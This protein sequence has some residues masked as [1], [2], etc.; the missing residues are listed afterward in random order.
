[1]RLSCHRDGQVQF[2]E[3]KT[4]ATAAAHD[5]ILMKVQ[6]LSMHLRGIEVVRREDRQ[7]GA[8][9]R[10][11]DSW[12]EYPFR[13]NEGSGCGNAGRAIDHWI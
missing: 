6:A 8:G 1:M 5:E 3:D 4:L 12:Y 11:S 9:Y 10:C 13:E 7:A 2:V